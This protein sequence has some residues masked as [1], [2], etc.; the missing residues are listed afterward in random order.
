MGMFSGC[1]GG[2]SPDDDTS[3]TSTSV[4]TSELESDYDES[5]YTYDESDIV[6]ITLSGSAV[7]IDTDGL[8]TIDGSELTITSAGTYSI[9]GS[10]TD[11]RIVVNTDDADVVQLIFDGVDISCS[12]SAPVY[13]EN[14]ERTA[15]ILA[16]D[17][18]NYLEDASTYT[19]EDDED[20]P[21]AALH[22]KDYL[23]F[24][25]SG[26]LTVNGNYNDGITSKD[27][28]IIAN[29]KITVNA[30]DDGIRG[31]DYLIVKQGTISVTTDAGDGFKSDNDEDTE[32]GYVTIE[33]GSIDIAAEGDAI[34]AETYVTVYNGDIVIEAGGG[35][36]TSFDENDSKKGIKGSSAVLIE[37][38]DLT[39]NSADDAIHSNGEIEIDDGI[40]DIETGDDGIHA[41]ESIVIYGGDFSI[42]DSYEGIESAVISIEDGIYYINSSDDGLNCAGGNDG[43]GYAG[44]GGGDDGTSSTDSGDYYLYIDGGY[45]AVYAQGDGLDSNGSIEMTGGTVLVHGPTGDGNGSLDSGDSADD[46][47][48]TNGGFLIA[49]GSDGMVES[50]DSSSDQKYQTLKFSTRTGGTLFHIES[51]SGTDIVTFR[52]SKD[53]ESIVISS[54]DF[55]TGTTYDVYFGGTYTDG[56]ET[57]G[58]CEGG[59]Y[60]GGTRVSSL[61]FSL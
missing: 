57:D 8:A 10:L 3:S 26:S 33:D 4:D 41:D 5:D 29:G 28:L 40:F 37:A 32:K 35:N 36:G 16:E 6:Y 9:S 49:S 31:K 24:S 45:L 21:N 58:L 30:V 25:G 52:P 55:E 34:D 51:S 20:E 14:A 47:I 13:I 22:S 50:P 44:P 53:Y 56:D 1:G 12:D 60:S 7:T 43:S 15:I 2:D 46:E 39:I 42:T 48:L 23:T 59:S 18:D 11:G 54:P 17:S 27:G 61:S 19:Y 38:G